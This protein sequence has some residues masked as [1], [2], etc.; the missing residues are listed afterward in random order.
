MHVGQRSAVLQSAGVCGSGEAGVSGP[1]P[2]GDTD[3]RL[4]FALH[5]TSAAPYITT[6]P[7]K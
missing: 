5:V 6:E 3:Q 7:P 4:F 2:D 1:A